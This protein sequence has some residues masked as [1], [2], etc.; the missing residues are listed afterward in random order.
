MSNSIKL[1]KLF[2][3]LT[4]SDIFE[5]FDEEYLIKMAKS[6]PEQLRRMCIFLTLDEQVRKEKTEL[7]SKENLN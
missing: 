3:E 4:F 2:D 1:E 6:N 7:T 5:T